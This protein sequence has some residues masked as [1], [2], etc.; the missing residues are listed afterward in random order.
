MPDPLAQEF[1]KFR[2]NLAT[3]VNTVLPRGSLTALMM[4]ARRARSSAARVLIEH[5]AD[6]NL[7]RSGRDERSVLAIINGHYDVGG[8]ARGSGRRSRISR[9]LGHGGPLRAVDM[10]TQP[11]MIN[12]PTRKPSGA[13]ENLDLMKRLMAHGADTNA[14]VATALLARYH[15][16]G[17]NQ[18]GAGVD[19]A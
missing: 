7:T 9:Q 16:T 12:R 19:A 14:P 8:A 15:N 10:H 2:F 3:M 5:G 1:A 18:L 17:D 6:V 13:V 11:P 4:A